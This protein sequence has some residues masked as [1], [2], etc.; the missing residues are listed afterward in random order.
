MDGF[1]LDGTS[2]CPHNGLEGSNRKLLDL[3]DE[4]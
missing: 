2:D 4:A 3:K 1:R